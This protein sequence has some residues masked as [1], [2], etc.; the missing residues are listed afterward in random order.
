MDT[1]ILAHIEYITDELQ[2]LKA[3]RL[4]LWLQLGEDFIA[5][6][7][8]VRDIAAATGYGRT[9]VARYMRLA[10][11]ELIIDEVKKPQSVVHSMKQDELIDVVKRDSIEL[12]V[13]R[14]D[15]KLHVPNAALIKANRRG[16]YT[17]ALERWKVGEV[18]AD[19]TDTELEEASGLY[20]VIEDA[21]ATISES[22]MSLAR[23][24][25]RLLRENY[26]AM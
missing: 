12:P 20:A 4:E 24:D 1:S 21:L 5:L 19:L 26:E 17:R 6:N 23:I 10:G 3:S 14:A 13:R 22:N 25:S 8:P 15:K 9:A 7:A 16:S 11:C 2:R 18:A